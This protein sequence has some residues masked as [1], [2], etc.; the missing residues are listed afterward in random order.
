M[1]DEGVAR[2]PHQRWSKDV[3]VIV[4]T[5]SKRPDALMPRL[6]P[7]KIKPVDPLARQIGKNHAPQENAGRAF[8]V[9]FVIRDFWGVVSIIDQESHVHR[10]RLV[11]LVFED[12]GVHP[13][14]SL[15]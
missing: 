7:K 10:N 2:S 4:R 11:G 14:V 3:A 9:R 5:S 8:R 13:E 12:E 15:P 1:G 6:R